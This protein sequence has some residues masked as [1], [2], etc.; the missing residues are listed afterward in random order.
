M[1]VTYIVTR[2]VL[3]GVIGLIMASAVKNGVFY[4][5]TYLSQDTNERGT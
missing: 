2:V 3:F 5:A 4:T 1:E